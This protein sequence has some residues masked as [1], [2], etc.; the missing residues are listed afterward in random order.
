MRVGRISRSPH[1]WPEARRERVRMPFQKL[2]FEADYDDVLMSPKGSH[3]SPESRSRW[4]D[5]Q[6]GV[7]DPFEEGKLSGRLFRRVPRFDSGGSSGRRKPD[8][9]LRSTARPGRFRRGYQ[10]N[11]SGAERT[12]YCNNYE[13]FDQIRR[14]DPSD[15][16]RR[17]RYDGEDCFV[18]QDAQNEDNSYIRSVGR[19]DIRSGREERGPFRYNRERTNAIGPK[20]SA[21][22]DEDEDASPPSG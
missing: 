17:F 18:V 16:V 2:T 11:G 9:C 15:R 3:F 10:Y 20:L 19:R 22:G 21:I 5:D 14:R 7:V 1:L 8:D 6:N 13:P 4:F 12:K